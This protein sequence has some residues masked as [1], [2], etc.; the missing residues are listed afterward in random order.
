[1]WICV[2]LQV[3]K[4]INHIHKYDDKSKWPNNKYNQLK[5]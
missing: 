1:M 4:Y 2:R 5:I 3:R